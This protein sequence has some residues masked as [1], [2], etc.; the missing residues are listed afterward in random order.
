MR[1]LLWQCS[2][3]CETDIWKGF[4]YVIV[5]E[6][7]IKSVAGADVGLGSDRRRTTRALL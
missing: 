2:L 6:F 1:E 3:L 7:S 5:A 4:V